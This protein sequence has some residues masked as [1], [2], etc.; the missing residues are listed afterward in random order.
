MWHGQKVYFLSDRDENKKANLWAYELKREKLRQVTFFKDYDVHFPSLGPNDLVFE[1]AGQLYL[2][3]LATEK[4][5]PVSITVL[6][7]RA[8]LKPPAVSCFE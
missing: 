8:T 6:T 4:Y 3:D 1:Y 2:L 5:A 7:D